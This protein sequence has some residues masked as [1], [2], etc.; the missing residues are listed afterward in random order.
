MPFELAPQGL[1]DCHCIFEDSNHSLAQEVAEGFSPTAHTM[2]DRS[3]RLSFDFASEDPNHHP[4][5]AVGRLREST[6]FPSRGCDFDRRVAPVGESEVMSL[7]RLHV[8]KRVA[9]QLGLEDCPDRGLENLG[10]IEE[11]K[12]RDFRVGV[13]KSDRDRCGDLPDE[14]LGLELL[15]RAR[16]L[17][18]PFD[19]ETDAAL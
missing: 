13:N 7:E 15:I 11:L 8:S 3:T 1:R 12:A 4:A 19:I 2:D 6:L 18:D 5:K 9:H 16:K 10:R 17:A 14:Q